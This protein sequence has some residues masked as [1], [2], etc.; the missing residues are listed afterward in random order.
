MMM[1]MAT[2]RIDRL[3]KS[4][5]GLTSLNLTIAYT[6]IVR[7]INFDKVSGSV[8]NRFHELWG[9][10]VRVW[11]YTKLKVVGPDPS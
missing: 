1:R 10:S 5:T 4:N 6:E 11:N 2:P 7:L 9:T 3:W 8:G